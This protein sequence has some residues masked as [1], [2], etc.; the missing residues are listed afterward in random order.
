MAKSM[1]RVHMPA[2]LALRRVFLAIPKTCALA[3]IR[4]PWQLRPG[5][6]GQAHAFVMPKRL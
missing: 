5:N 2:L 3:G 4:G 1:G 6:D